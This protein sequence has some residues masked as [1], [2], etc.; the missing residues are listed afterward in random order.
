MILIILLLLVLP[1]SLV[2]LYGAPYLP[3]RRREAD[4]ALDMLHLKKGEVFVD[5]G[6][7]DGAVLLVAAKRGMVCYGYELNPLVWAIAMIRTRKFRSTVKV[8]CRNFWREPLPSATKGVFVFLLDKYMERLDEKLTQEM[9][10]GVLLSY[11]FQIPG[12]KPVRTQGACFLYKYTPKQ[13][14]EK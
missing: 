1:F 3:T 12:K 13:R 4:L 5:L 7:G 8:Y 11:A 10:N 9:P 14:E 6:C 2:L